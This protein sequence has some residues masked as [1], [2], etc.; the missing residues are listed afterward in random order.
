[1]GNPQN[2]G[3]GRYSFKDNI[4][5]PSFN[6]NKFSLFSKTELR[7]VV[8]E[9]LSKLGPGSYDYDYRLLKKKL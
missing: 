2:I 3:P 1:M 6:T 8:P 9:N 5:K 4:V 7:S